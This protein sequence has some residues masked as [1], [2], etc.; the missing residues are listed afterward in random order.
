MGKLRNRRGETLTETLCAVLVAAL[1]VA[2]LAGMVSATSRL[3]RKTAQAAGQLY[4]SVNQA[5]NAGPATGTG[6]IAVQVAGREVELEVQF[7]G[8]KDQVVSYRREPEGM[9]P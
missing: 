3:D 2:L 8:N 4:Q 9:E 7:Y 6:E 1:A 5:E